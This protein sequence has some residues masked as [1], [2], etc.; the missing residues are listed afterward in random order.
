MINVTKQRLKYIVVDYL[1]TAIAL[2]IFNIARY[3]LVDSIYTQYSSIWIFL[4]ARGVTQGLIIIPPI[5][6]VIYYLAGMYDYIIQRSRL[7]ELLST[8]TTS[9][10]GA[11]LY[12][13]TALINDYIPQTRIN[14]E[15]ILLLVAVL[16]ICVYSCRAIITQYTT[17]KIFSGEWGYNTLIVGTSN[18]AQK[19]ARE[20]TRRYRSMGLKVVGYV[21][22]ISGL[23]LPKNI[24]KPVYDIDSLDEIVKQQNIQKLIIAPHRNGQRATVDIINRLYP[25]DLSMFITPDL[26]NLMTMRTRITNVAAMPLIDISRSDMPPSTLNLKRF[27]DIII[28]ATALILLSPILVVIAILI[29]LD[30]PGPVLYRQQ[31]IGYHKRPFNIIKF[32]TMTVDAEPDGPALST[33][34]D[35]RIT[36]LGRLLRKY[37]LDELPN[38]WNVLRG[39]MS[40]VGPRP[41][42]DFYIRQILERAPYYTMVH[43]VRPGITSWGMVQYGYANSI[44]GMIERLKY[45]L[46]YLENVSFLIDI[47]ILIYTIRTVITGRGM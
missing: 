15:M 10:I 41:E 46:L 2:V 20:L 12:F 11:L 22:T 17:K 39:D 19:M 7:H 14:Y 30:S 23:E 34:D 16:F 3:N 43:Q 18:E 1:S 33:E 25:L 13:F 38:F 45:D 32:R 40:L 28:S 4:Q 35:P 26:Y 44:D 9:C 8:F 47:K 42:R 24:D 5:M 6:M 36:R 31:R 37:R 27:S 21:N 29:K